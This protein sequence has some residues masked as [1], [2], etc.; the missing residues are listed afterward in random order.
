MSSEFLP[1]SRIDCVSSPVTSFRLFQ[2]RWSMNPIS[3]RRKSKNKADCRY[4]YSI[5]G[6]AAWMTNARYLSQMEIETIT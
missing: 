2:T 5:R 4:P 6:K 3:E 1:Q